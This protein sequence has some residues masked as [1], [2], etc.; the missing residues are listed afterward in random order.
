MKSYI[1]GLLTCLGLLTAI[2]LCGPG[3][4][5]ALYPA[6]PRPHL[7]VET[8]W[9]SAGAKEIDREVTQPLLSAFSTLEGP[10][11]SIAK[12]ENGHS[13]VHLTFT[14]SATASQALSRVQMNLAKAIYQL[15]GE[16]HHPQVQTQ[17]ENVL[18]VFAVAF[19]LAKKR[20]SQDFQTEA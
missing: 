13:R 12:S 19:P 3:V 14:H 7:L 11:K 6:L 9:P 20:A 15:P 5:P 18:P 16:A 10:Q 2:L 4:S 8:R 1:I 17:G